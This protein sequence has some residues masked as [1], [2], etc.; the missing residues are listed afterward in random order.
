M[1]TDRPPPDWHQD[2]VRSSVRV[3]TSAHRHA[4]VPGLEDSELHGPAATTTVFPGV[5]MIATCADPACNIPFHYFRSGQIF[6][7]EAN[8]NHVDPSLS[9]HFKSG[10]RLSLQ[11]RPT[12]LAVQD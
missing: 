11:N 5:T 9:D 3:N 10:Q 2:R 8:D 7:V 1:P 6:M 12:G 4:L